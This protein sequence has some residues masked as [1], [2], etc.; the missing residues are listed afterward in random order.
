MRVA[1]FDFAL[2][3]SLVAQEP[4]ARRD[5]SRLL[6]VDRAAGTIQPA[7]FSRF[8]DLL[9]PNDLLVLNDTRVIP[10]RLF[11]QKASGGRVEVLLVRRQPGGDEVWTC[12]VRASKPPRPGT[13]L[14][15][16]EGVRAEVLGPGDQ[17]TWLLAFRD[18]TDFAAWLDRCGNLPLPPYIRRQ[19]VGDDRERY[20]T[21]YARSAGA[22]AAP[23]AGLHLTVELLAHLEQKGIPV[24]YLTLHVGLG[25]FL[26]VRVE[27]VA[28]HR[29][30]REH[31][32]IPADTAA[33]I[34][35]CRQRGGRVVAVGT[36]VV[37]T[38]E[39]AANDDGTVRTGEGE[40]DIFICPGYGF[41]VV[42]ALLTNF[43]LPKSTLLMLVSAFAGKELLFRAYERAIDEQ[44][45]FF[46]YGDAMFIA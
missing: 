34:T 37:R 10:A 5:A 32:R 28:D 26:P 9:G 3:E 19:P 15:L 38:L 2:P 22:V 8:A 25:T 46:S 1:D 36:T 14:T 16:A 33:A 18:C 43:H 27:Q 23:T 11:G 44:F 4:V 17:D 24:A 41:K 29:M 35:A 39:H 42:D 45:R 6:V 20:Q 12:L 21:V 40:T 13:F 31:Y 30:H 7:S